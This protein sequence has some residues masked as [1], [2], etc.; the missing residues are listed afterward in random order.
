[1]C[2]VTVARN[3][4]AYGLS[5]YHSNVWR[6]ASSRRLSAPRIAEISSVGCC[7]S[8]RR[9]DIFSC[10]Y[11]WVCRGLLQCIR[12]WHFNIKS[13]VRNPVFAV[14]KFRMFVHL[15]LWTMIRSGIYRP[16]R[17]FVPE[18]PLGWSAQ[19]CP[20][21]RV[22][23]YKFVRCPGLGCTSLSVAPGWAVQLCP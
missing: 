15:M 13:S 12:Y 23:L 9:F 1:M 21:P 8:S 6:C 19:V 10:C 3:A 16:K 14:W 11:W 18:W 4:R 20:L 5:S 17:L 2:T 22:G 7:T